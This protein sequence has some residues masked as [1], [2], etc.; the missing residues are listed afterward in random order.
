[1][2]QPLSFAPIA[3]LNHWRAAHVLQTG[4]TNE[5]LAALAAAG[6]GGDGRIWLTAGQQRDG[7][8]RRARGWHS[9]QGNLHASTLLIDPAPLQMLGHLPLVAALGARAAI[10]AEIGDDDGLV[11]IKWPND[12]LIDGAK[13]CGILL[14]SRSVADGHMAVIAGFGINIV[15]HPPDTPYPATHL[16]QWAKQSASTSM[17]QHLAESF[18]AMFQL[19]RGGANLTEIRAQ[20]LAHARGLGKPLRV[21]THDDSIDGVFEQMDEDGQLVLRLPDGTHKR[22]ASAEIFF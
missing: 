10:A 18:A 11:Q 3:G 2:N 20:W 9:P 17:F 7:R 19:W 22:F 12:I 21:N 1:M 4:S 6:A 15:A 8:G 14:E 5:D 16:R 13:C